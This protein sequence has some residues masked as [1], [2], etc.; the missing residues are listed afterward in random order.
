MTMVEERSRAAA[1]AR[2]R[3]SSLMEPLPL[4]LPAGKRLGPAIASVRDPRNGD[5]LVVHHGDMTGQGDPDILPQVVRFSPDYAFVE[6][7]GGPDHIPAEGGVS[8]WPSGPEGIEC[9]A[10]GNIW[11]F[12]YQKPDSAVLRFS[13]RGELVMRLGQR[14]RI[15]GEDDTTLFGSGPTS[16]WHDVEN[17]EVFISDG[18]SNHRVI[19]FNSDTG[20][21]TRMW[22]A[23]GKAPSAVP[24][25]EQYGNPVHKVARGPDGLLYVCDRL[26]GRVQAFELIPGG[27]R[28]VR[29]VVLAPGTWGFGAAF[30]ICFS[31]DGGYAYVA[32][33]A[34][35]RIWILGLADLSILGWTIAVPQP[36]GEANEPAW[37]RALHRMSIEPNGD[38]ILACTQAGFRRL[39]LLGVS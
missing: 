2:P 17:R 18:Y 1:K 24:S 8:Q 13:P 10:E 15:G 34:N 16:C 27:A 22:G 25:E 14:E 4:K 7:W 33:G 5:L 9:D 12:G 29:E 20:A 30:D 39:K 31:P 21:F 3:F 36:E 37:H 35:A 23:Y 11:I 38:I 6:A 19:A 26:K 28:Y 32:D